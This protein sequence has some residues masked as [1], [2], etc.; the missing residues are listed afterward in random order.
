MRSSNNQTLN[1]FTYSENV[2]EFDE[3]PIFADHFNGN[4]GFEYS[5]KHQ[6]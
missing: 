3:T 6:L 4:M 1:F 2:N 5:G